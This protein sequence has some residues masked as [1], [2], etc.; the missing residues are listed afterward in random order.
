MKNNLK[1]VKEFF[2]TDVKKVNKFLL[3]IVILVI[4]SGVSL[5]SFALFSYEVYSPTYIMLTYDDLK[6]PK[7][8]IE[9]PSANEVNINTNATYTMTCT[10]K[11]GVVEKDITS[12]DFI[13]EGDITIQN[14]TKETVTNGFKYTINI[15]SGTTDSVANIKFKE[16]IIQDN[17]GNN[18]KESNVSNNITV[19]TYKTFYIT[20]GSTRNEYHYTPGMTFQ[21]FI[22]S[23]Y[24][25]GLVSNDSGYV[26]YNTEY[27]VYSGST[28]LTP[29]VQITENANYTTQDKVAKLVISGGRINATYDETYEG[30]DSACDER[31]YTTIHYEAGYVTV[32]STKYVSTTLW[33]NKN[34]KISIYYCDSFSSEKA[35]TSDWRSYQ[36][37]YKTQ[38]HTVSKNTYVNFSSVHDRDNTYSSCDP[39]Y[40][41][42]D[43]YDDFYYFSVTVS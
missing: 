25:N 26:A 10:D 24:N 8:V 38:S 39:G 20:Y 29:T 14:I 2:L 12:N 31:I 22:S 28:R 16:N 15:L 17:N 1:K 34:T 40:I 7:C 32:N 33:V 3:L 37:N 21:D 30:T 19:V 42:R 9:G 27:E 6:G 5:T 11:A 13:V 4:L 36:P 41:Y 43:Y 35:P 23:K 18:N